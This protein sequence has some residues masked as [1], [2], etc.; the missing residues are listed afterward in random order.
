M[1]KIQE[2]GLANFSKELQNAV[3]E[4][5]RLD[6]DKND[7]VPQ[8][9]GGFFECELYLTDVATSVVTEVKPVVSDEPVSDVLN[10][11]VLITQ[12][13]VGNLDKVLAGFSPTDTIVSDVSAPV[14]PAKLGRPKRT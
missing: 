13:D 1:K 7:G 6:L 9:Y 12:V 3:L 5:Y 4:G 11:K 10:E 2:Y 14:A 8:A